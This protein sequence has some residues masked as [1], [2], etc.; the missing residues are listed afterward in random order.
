MIVTIILLVALVF[1]LVGLITN[2]WQGKLPWIGI[3]VLLVI[4]V[5]LGGPWL[6]R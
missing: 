2:P 3:A 5:M 4:I 1:C 6:I